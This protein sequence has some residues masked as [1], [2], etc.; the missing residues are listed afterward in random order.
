MVSLQAINSIRVIPTF[1]YSRRPRFRAVSVRATAFPTDIDIMNHPDNH[2]RPQL[3]AKRRAAQTL[4]LTMVTTISLLLAVSGAADTKATMDDITFRNL[5]T[6]L[7]KSSVVGYGW[8]APPSEDKQLVR[9]MVYPTLALEY[10]AWSSSNLTT[11]AIAFLLH[12]VMGIPIRMTESSGQSNTYDRVAE[13]LTHMYAEIWPLSEMTL[14][15]KYVVEE[16][17]VDYMGLL[18]Y[19]GRISL[20]FPRFIVDAHPDK[21]FTS[22]RS[23]LQ[24][25]V[26][27]YLPMQGTTP[28]ER[29]DSGEFMC[30]QSYCTNGIYVPPQCLPNGTWFGRCRELWHVTP[31][32]SVGVNE[33]RIFDLGLPL[34]VVYLGNR[35]LPLLYS[36]KPSSAC[37]P[38]NVSILTRLAPDRGLHG[39]RRRRSPEMLA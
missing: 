17:K 23:L 37:T 34:V 20:Y 30:T 8:I 5:P 22:W 2:R 27:Q 14:F 29:L 4:V 38:S 35:F 3:Q 15:R 13:G 1:T 25:E 21:V 33:Q 18:G 10:S 31:D 16:A 39:T 28:T 26:L 24:P 36:P 12:D 11:Y 7:P 6:C 32:Y 19:A 9:R